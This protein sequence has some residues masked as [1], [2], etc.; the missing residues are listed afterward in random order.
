[1]YRRYV[2]M[3]LLFAIIITSDRKRER[4]RERER[5]HGEKIDQTDI[6][7]AIVITT[8]T[9]NHFFT[10]SH[11]HTIGDHVDFRASNCFSLSVYFRVILD[12]LL[13]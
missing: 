9:I 4:E 7:R 11:A 13:T 6:Y 5:V 1:M 2:M 10:R 8:K 12:A 3:S